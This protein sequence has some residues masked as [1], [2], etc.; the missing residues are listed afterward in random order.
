MT[1]AQSTHRSKSL[2]R[3]RPVE[4]AAVARNRSTHL[5]PGAGFFPLRLP[6]ARSPRPGY[7][8]Y[9]TDDFLRGFDAEPI[10]RPD[11]EDNRVD[12]RRSR[13]KRCVTATGLIIAAAAAIVLTT[14]WARAGSARARTEPRSAPAHGASSAAVTHAVRRG[15]S[16]DRAVLRRVTESET[17]ARGDSAASRR[18][19]GRPRAYRPA[20]SQL[21][22]L[23]AVD[24][25]SP[26]RERLTPRTQATRSGGSS[27]FGFEG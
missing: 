13:V 19:R 21:A 6:V 22:R 23:H 4:R 8:I 10:A 7:R 14:T 5:R 20:K 24:P 16:R 15:S 2:A 18:G 25:P 27:E 12:F 11:T 17:G 1:I 26:A 3:R 9:A